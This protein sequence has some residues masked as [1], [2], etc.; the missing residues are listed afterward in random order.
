MP[1]IDC[2]RSSVVARTPRV[3]Q[4]ESM[5]EL[6][7]AATAE[8]RW[9]LDL[10]LED[11]EWQIGLIVGPSGAGKSTIARELF[12]EHIVDELVW[13]ADRSVLDGFG[14]ELGI[15]DVTG[16]LSAV[17]FSSPPSWLRPFQVLSTGEKFRATMA[18]AL[19]EAEDLVVID[20]FTSVV[21]RQVARA[22]CAAVSKA[23]RR[24]GRRFV[25]VG[26]HYDVLEWLQPDWICEPHESLFRW[27]EVQQRPRV[28]LDIVPVH[29]QAWQLF[30]QHHYL[31]SDI[32]QPARCF[33]AMWDGV[34][35]AFGAATVAPGQVSFWRGHRVVCL[36]DYQGMGIGNALAEWMGWLFSADKPYIV[37]S[38]NP[39]FVRHRARSKLWRMTRAPSRVQE[40]PVDARTRRG[41]FAKSANRVTASFRYVGPRATRDEFERAMTSLRDPTRGS[42]TTRVDR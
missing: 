10:P 8:V 41:R 16:W 15:K 24:G 18:R 36:P 19:A 3:M 12:G 42:P 28:N 5:F 34:P 9:S 13:P 23:V 35:V 38:S 25:G 40:G 17:G 1:R 29:R 6:P 14:P 4:A 30:K 26:C 22:A 21:D 7:A 27:R 31:N 37:C 32:H 2:V 33:L 39:A 11:R 20:E